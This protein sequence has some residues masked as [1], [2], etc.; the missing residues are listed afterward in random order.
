MDEVYYIPVICP[1]CRAE[2]EITYSLGDSLDFRCCVCDK[3]FNLE[4]KNI[5]R[6]INRTEHQLFEDALADYRRRKSMGFPE[7]RLQ[8]T[9]NG[10]YGS[11]RNGFT[12]PDDFPSDGFGG[13]G[14]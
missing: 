10:G 14:W 5:N 8:N 3:I 6:Y 1:H 4:Q 11:G 13:G 9:R 7:R 12:D 2:L